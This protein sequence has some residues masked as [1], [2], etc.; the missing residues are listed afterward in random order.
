MAPDAYSRP[1]SSPLPSA[2]FA[3]SE[4]L[5]QKVEAELTRRLFRSSAFAPIFDL[6]LAAILVAG[7]WTYF[8]ASNLLV[9]LGT[10]AAVFLARFAV[11]HLFSRRTRRDEELPVWRRAFFAGI[12]ATAMSWG[13]AGWLYLDTPDVLP[14]CLILFV[15]AGLNAGAAHALA[16]AR[17]FYFIFALLTFAP[18]LTV[19]LFMAETGSWTLTVCTIAYAGFLIN[20]TRLRHA[21][22]R[23]SY[24]S[25]F[26]REELLRAL[27]T[28]GMRAEEANTAKSDFLA[29]MGHEIRTPMNGLIGMLQL[30]RDSDLGDEQREQINSAAAS[31]HALLRLLNDILDL[32]RI[33]SGQLVL[34]TIPFSVRDTT[35][36]AIF[37][38]DD[39]A[40]EKRLKLRLTVADGLP[41]SVTGDPGRLKQV[42]INLI[43]NALKFTEAGSVDV[44]LESA[45]AKP[46]R[47]GFGFRVRDTGIGMDAESVGKLFT[48]FTRADNSTTRRHSGSGLGLAIAQELV[49]QMGGEI[50]V[51]SAPGKG[52]EFS[53]EISLPLLPGQAG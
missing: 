26:E 33:E 1:K 51:R 25:S 28:A 41:D 8:P 20:S 7:L 21:D 44:F 35:E 22:L 42:L 5:R 50:R 48:K 32:A 36:E 53:F 14:Q 38:M 30:V 17:R 9:W 6:G 18:V 40:E 24:G 15:L 2:G 13:A 11:T 29:T 31:A 19:P 43:G 34:E 3:E 46:G 4:T 49:R 12:V 10:A 16:P 27:N 37:F 47:A 45:P 52:S 23:R 39:R